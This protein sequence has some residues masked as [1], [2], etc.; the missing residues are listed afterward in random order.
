[1]RPRQASYCLHAN[2]SRHLLT[3]R[4]DSMDDRHKIDS[5]EELR[6]LAGVLRGLDTAASASQWNDDNAMRAVVAAAHAVLA[7]GDADDIGATTTTHSEAEAAAIASVGRA[8]IAVA[9]AVLA[10]D[11]ARR[12]TTGTP[13]AAGH[14]LRAVVASLSSLGRSIL[15]EVR[16]ITADRPRSI[17]LRIVIT[18]G[19]GLALVAAYHLTGMKRYDLSGLTLYL[20]SVV[21]GSV[22]CTN[23]LCFEAERVRTALAAGQRVW[24]VLVVQNIAMA[25][26][27][28]IAGLPVIAALRWTREANPVALVDQ[29]VTMVFIWLGVGNVLAVLYPLRHEPMAAR[30]KDGTWKPFLFSFV[31]SYGVGLTVNLMIYWRL[32]ARQTANAQITGG[33]WVAF[34]LVLASAILSWMLLTVFAVAC[35]QQPIVRRKL[36]REMIAYRQPA[37]S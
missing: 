7:L 26:L 5:L 36:S 23:S 24:R 14:P 1:M 6:S 2:R 34:L 8:R 3:L 21:V 35:S 32:W 22:V 9:E 4:S 29:L 28:T 13:A 33:A 19:V 31:L 18:V 12:D 20:F 37:D 25:V 17:L 27:I 11:S 10:V 15:D 30:L 16:H